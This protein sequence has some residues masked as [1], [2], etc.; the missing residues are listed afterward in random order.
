ML[1]PQDRKRIPHS[2]YRLARPWRCDRDRKFGPYE[3]H[4]TRNLNLL[5]L[6][7]ALELRTRAAG[8]DL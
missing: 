8:R 5:N 7:R 2:L 3:R 4:V 6:R 1:T